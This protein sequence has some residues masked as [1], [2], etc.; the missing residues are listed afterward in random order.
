M[1]EALFGRL[2]MNVIYEGSTSYKG[3]RS[4]TV[5]VLAHDH[6]HTVYIVK[7]VYELTREAVRDLLKIIEEFPKFF[8]LFANRTIY[9]MIGAYK[10]PKELRDEVQQEG[11]YL[12]R[13]AD[14]VFRLQV[15][16]GFKPKA[17]EPATKARPK[18][19]RGGQRQSQ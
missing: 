18:T 5:D 2:K 9:G 13:V 8:P 15:P 16:R 3:K 17:F 14:G 10:I 12:A 1:E 19:F 11:F 6:D 7:I 4:L